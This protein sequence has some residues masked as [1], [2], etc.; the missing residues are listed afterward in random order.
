M[1]SSYSETTDGENDQARDAPLSDH[2]CVPF[3]THAASVNKPKT[4]TAMGFEL[5]KCM[6]RV[7]FN[8]LRWRGE[9]DC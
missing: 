4:L 5:H 8:E 9:G 2:S 6:T 1:F 7:E 3:Q